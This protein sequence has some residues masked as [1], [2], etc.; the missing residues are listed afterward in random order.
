MHFCPQEAMAIIA[1]IPVLRWLLSKVVWW[2]ARYKFHAPAPGANGYS[3]SETELVEVRECRGCKA[4][5]EREASLDA[6]PRDLVRER[7][8]E[9]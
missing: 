2:R 9:P 6:T 7:L 8:G 5:I 3:W 1:A 4:E